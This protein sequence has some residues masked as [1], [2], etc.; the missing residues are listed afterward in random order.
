MRY[1]SQ[2]DLLS[3]PE[4]SNASFVW[5]SLHS[6]IAILRQGST[7]DVSTNTHFCNMSHDGI[8]TVKSA[9]NFIEVS[10]SATRQLSGPSSNHLIEQIWKTIWRMA[11]PREIQLFFWKAYHN[12]LPVGSEMFRRFGLQEVNCKI[13][14]YK[15]ETPIHLLKECW[16]IKP[17]W[18]GLGLNLSLL[19]IQFSYFAD[20]VFFLST[21]LSHEEFRLAI[22]AFWYTW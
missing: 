20:W 17:L 7:F 18:G 1:F 10:P 11:I 13:C 4:K 2:C 21:S 14:N 6:A 8:Y 19:S 16:W 12:G 5:K 3:A 15:V 22:T 9:Y